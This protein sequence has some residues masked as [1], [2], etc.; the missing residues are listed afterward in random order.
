MASILLKSAPWALIAIAAFGWFKSE[1]A[2]ARAEGRRE[3]L[4]AQHDSVLVVLDKERAIALD[5]VTVIQERIDTLELQVTPE[6]IDS[7]LAEIP[8][9]VVRERVRTVVDTLRTVCMLCQRQVTLLSS[10]LDVEVSHHNITRGLLHAEQLRK[11]S[12]IS[13]GAT[14]GVGAVYAGQPAFGPGVMVG[15]TVRF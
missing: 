15:I 3:V 13:F 12:W 6:A 4:A 8:D 7:A 10:A 2:E 9:P 1:Q 5:T 14:V 11:E